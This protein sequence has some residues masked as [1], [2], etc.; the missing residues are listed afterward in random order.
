MAPSVDI[1]ATTS[2]VDRRDD[3]LLKYASEKATAALPSGPDD[4]RFEA[5]KVTKPMPHEIGIKQG[6]QEKQRQQKRDLETKSVFFFSVAIG[7][8]VGAASQ[9]LI[10]SEVGQK[11]MV[12]LMTAGKKEVDKQDFILE[13]LT[14]SL[15][16]MQLL[17]SR[18]ADVESH[19]TNVS[20]LRT[21][22]DVDMASNLSRPS[23]QVGQSESSLLS[24]RHC[25]AG[26]EPHQFPVEAHSSIHLRFRRGRIYQRLAGRRGGWRRRSGDGG[27]SMGR[28]PR[29][30]RFHASCRVAQPDF[31]R[32]PHGHEQRLAGIYPYML[33]SR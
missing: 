18:I 19:I 23:V 7:K 10:G 1:I 26:I 32:S 6:E 33:R 3:Q 17:Q 20:L 22:T 8:L 25:H 13:K 9:G 15:K 2:P 11:G 31:P 30:R 5:L 14:E 28:H 27:Q 12:F 4:Y 21:V 16:A 29:I 24:S